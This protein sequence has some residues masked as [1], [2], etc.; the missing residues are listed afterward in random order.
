MDGKDVGPASSA[1]VLANQTT[2]VV[3]MDGILMAIFQEMRIDEWPDPK[4]RVDIRGKGFSR[5]GSHRAGKAARPIVAN[6]GAAAS[7]LINDRRS[8]RLDMEPAVRPSTLMTSSTPPFCA[9]NSDWYD[10]ARSGSASLA[11][12]HVVTLYFITLYFISK[13]RLGEILH[14]YKVLS[15]KSDFRAIF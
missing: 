11:G 5:I 15:I 6:R 14:A 4:T 3:R 1:G 10:R 12:F 7:N 13:Q 8:F 2:S 9:N